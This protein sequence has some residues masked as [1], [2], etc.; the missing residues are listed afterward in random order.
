MT[1]EKLN[2]FNE[3]TLK[4]IAKSSRVSESIKSSDGKTTWEKG[5]S[6]AD[7]YITDYL[8]ND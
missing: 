7:A 5:D 3:H 4:N 1:F 2:D 6:H 8:L